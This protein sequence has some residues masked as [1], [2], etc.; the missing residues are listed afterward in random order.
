[1][2]HRLFTIVLFLLLGAV[3]NVA[4]AW[5]CAVW[6]ASS[7]WRPVSGYTSSFARVERSRRLGCDR[8]ATDGVANN[9]VHFTS[10]ELES[11]LPLRALTGFELYVLRL[12]AGPNRRLV[13]GD[14]N[15]LWSLGWTSP[16]LPLR[17]LWPGFLANTLLCATL[18]WLLIPG[19]FALR[20]LIRRERG[21]CPKC[22]YPMGE[23]SICSEC[24]N[25]LPQP[26]RAAT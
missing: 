8:V 16:G 26:V 2:K 25:A 3:V 17:P 20:R 5:G 22:A 14:R 13:R 1:M 18:L 6:P 24:G 7:R 12:S 11:G 19:P 10:L 15:G 9:V 21:L 23:S 4:V